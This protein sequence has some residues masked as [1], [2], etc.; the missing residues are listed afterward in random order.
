MINRTQMAILLADHKDKMLASLQPAISNA[1]ANNMPPMPQPNTPVLAKMQVKIEKLSADMEDVLAACRAIVSAIGHLQN[2]LLP[3]EEEKVVE[4]IKVA[5]E[6]EVESKQEVPEEEPKVEVPEAEVPE[7]SP[8][9]EEELAEIESKRSVPA[10][11]PVAKPKKK[12][13]K[14]SAAKKKKEAVVR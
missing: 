14:K 9:M 10:K 1:L 13:A 6:R 12:A 7:V 11:A 5:I 3:E 2:A 4:D 8:A